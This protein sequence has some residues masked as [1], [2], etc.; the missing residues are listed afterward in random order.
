MQL[1]HNAKASDVDSF[2]THRD[3]TKEK[4]QRN[5]EGNCQGKNADIGY[6][7]MP[8]IGLGVYTGIH[9]GTH[10]CTYTDIQ[11]LCGPGSECLEPL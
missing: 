8:V 9:L 11:Y 2:S 5:R 6:K 4:P 3:G 7:S 1:Y 10:P